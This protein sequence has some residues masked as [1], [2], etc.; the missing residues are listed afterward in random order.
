MGFAL[1]LTGAALLPL[2]FY[3]SEKL[4]TSVGAGDN[5]GEVFVSPKSEA[6]KRGYAR[7]GEGTPAR[8]ILPQLDRSGKLRYASLGE[9]IA[10]SALILAA[11]VATLARPAARRGVGSP[12][13]ILKL[14]GASLAGGLFGGALL[15][16]L[17]IPAAK[18][19]GETAF[20][21]GFVAVVIATLL[22][23]VWAAVTKWN[24]S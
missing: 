14:F 19:P 2:S 18:L 11:V 23:A 24:P 12:S 22:F 21:V 9:L 7:P 3:V 4:N 16:I 15:G 17:L 20:N 13:E 5:T 1:V 8:T 6:A 10:G